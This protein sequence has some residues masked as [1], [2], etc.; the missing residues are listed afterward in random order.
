MRV[1]GRVCKASKRRGR[2]TRRVSG[3]A[4]LVVLTPVER[5]IGEG[6]HQGCHPEERLVDTDPHKQPQ[7]Y[8]F[9]DSPHD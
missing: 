6:L 9:N 5:G 2:Q 3:A 8:R 1:G 4:A 7:G